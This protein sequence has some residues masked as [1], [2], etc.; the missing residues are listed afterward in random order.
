MGEF[1]HFKWK[2]FDCQ[3]GKGKGIDNM[4]MDFICMLDEAREIAGIPFSITSGYRTPEYNQA[5]RE[6]GYG[7]SKNSSHMKG[8]AADISASDPTKR[9]KIIQA[10]L[11]VG[12]NRI[13][14]GDTFIHCDT[15]IQKNQNIIWTYY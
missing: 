5:L 4:K 7:A 15:D 9:F 2:E 3:S 1:K 12:F 11:K 14:I 6:E 13:G 10:L 8:I